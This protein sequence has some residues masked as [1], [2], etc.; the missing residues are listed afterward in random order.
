MLEADGT[1]TRRGNL[2]EHFYV[3]A[4]G[5]LLATIA[6]LDLD[7]ILRFAGWE[8][9]MNV[10]DTAKWVEWVRP[11][12][13]SKNYSKFIFNFSLIVLPS[14]SI[15][16]AHFFAKIR[17]KKITLF[18]L[19]SAGFFV[20]MRWGYLKEGLGWKQ[21]GIVN[22]IILVA[23]LLGLIV[24]RWLPRLGV[25]REPFSVLEFV[26]EGMTG[27]GAGKVRSFFNKYQLFLVVPL[28]FVVLINFAYKYSAGI[29]INYYHQNFLIAP[30]NDMLHG[31][32]FLVETFS[33][34]GMF[35][36]ITL[37]L[38]FYVKLLKFTYMNF[39]LIA[40]VFTV[41]YF[42]VLYYF[43]RSVTRGLVF[44]ILALFV[45]MGVNTLFNNAYFPYSEI[46]DW[47]GAMPLR[48]F[49]DG[50]V[51]WLIVRNNGFKN[52]ILSGLVPCLV[53]A[54]LY[55]NFETGVCLAA[56]YGAL[57]L[58][59]VLNGR[60][61]GAKAAA[62]LAK[63]V[64]SVSVGAVAIYLGIVFFTWVRI[65][66][67][68]ELDLLLGIPLMMAR[69]GYTALPTPKIGW[70]WA[71]LAVYF[72]V[73]VGVFYCVLKTRQTSW[74]WVVLG[75]YA[76]YGL[77]LLQYYMNKSVSSNLP[78]VGI[79]FAVLVVVV[80]EEVLGFLC[81]HKKAD[82]PLFLVVIAFVGFLASGVLAARTSCYL[83]KKINYRIYSK[84]QLKLLKKY[85][86]NNGLIVSYSLPPGLMAEDL[87]ASVAR[88]RELT[89]GQERIFLISR[90]DTVHLVM[91]E[92]TNY[93]PCPMLE[94]IFLK[95]QLAELKRN[96]INET[97]RPLYL[98]TDRGFPLSPITAPSSPNAYDVLVELFQGVEPY[99]ELIEQV[100]VINIYRLKK[101]LGAGV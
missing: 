11:G 55:Y 45:A 57:C 88:V 77:F 86:N 84:G 63:Q 78:V 73:F 82:W 26:S 15:L 39:Y 3:L 14:F 34:Y 32:Y 60:E 46:Y 98:F 31:K 83:V 62:F 96:L 44:A 75:A 37:F 89:K 43:I 92:K 12:F 40:M 101:S 10:I 19:S 20:F 66:K 48:F 41:G 21:L 79:P 70:Y 35:Y 80:T 25:S 85:E 23:Y 2:S 18:L 4:A 56:A 28:L 69:D 5:V 52:K 27:V 49:L 9:R 67:M 65:G 99:Y 29:W 87:L 47:P 16:L 30:I 7:F 90:H 17:T 100:G 1:S 8:A 94:Q 22:G 38:V 81:R 59:H 93:L 36:P 50:L 74:K 33:Q 64:G 13:F 51:F 58:L 91:A 72:S 53:A 97:K 6:I 61:G 76:V 68:P 54:A 71:Y 42:L 24:D 95:E